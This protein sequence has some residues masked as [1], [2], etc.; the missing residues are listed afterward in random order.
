[1]VSPVKT[2]NEIKLALILIVISLLSGLANLIPIY[3]QNWDVVSKQP[4]SWWLNAFSGVFVNIILM[5]LL[6]KGHNWVRW[7]YLVII[8]IATSVILFKSDLLGLE[9]TDENKKFLTR[10]I[11]IVVLRLIAATLL[12]LPASNRWFKLKNEN[13]SDK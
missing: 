13:I 6:A 12:F 8:L 3:S 1:M 9:A 10:E 2:P 5:F 7:L 4:I 11:P